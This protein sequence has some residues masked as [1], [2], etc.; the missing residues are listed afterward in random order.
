[1]PHFRANGKLLLTAE[2]FVLDE[3]VAL[4]LPC[5]FGQT[6]RA[7]TVE[8]P[9]L[10]WQSLNKEGQLWFEGQFSWPKGKY[11]T[12]TDQMVGERLE[13]IFQAIFAKRS[14]FQDVKGWEVTTR[15]EF[16]RKWGLG[17]SSTLI[18]NLAR[19]AN[20]NPY[21][22]LEATF[23][24]SGYDLAC[25]IADGPLLY[26]R[27][28]LQP[29]IETVAF[30]PPFKDQLYFVYLGKKQNSREG[31]ARYRKYGKPTSAEI[32]RVNDLT[33]LF[34]K[35]DA[36]DTFEGLIREH[37]AIIATKVKIKRAKT[38]YF[39]DFWGEIKS[40]GAWGGD[41]VLAT[42]KKSEAET[43][44]YFNKKGFYEILKYEELIL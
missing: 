1:M 17:T 31:I 20:V 37:E 5:R 38:L 24:G 15:L 19:W 14:T 42:S 40:L 16:P 32:H 34:L 30:N 41:F 12:G 3:A 27:Q 13:A 39:S 10:I 7:E 28:A 26:Q 2:Y 29:K 21:E 44:A 6:L 18:A 23:G 43:L 8:F 11:I 36:L 35:S 33:N 4:A 9:E 22:L 25:A